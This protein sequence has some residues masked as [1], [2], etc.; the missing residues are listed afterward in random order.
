MAYYQTGPRDVFYNHAH[1]Q[2][3]EIATEG[4]ALALVPMAVLVCALAWRVTRKLRTDRG[5]GM[6]LRAGAAGAL[7][8]LAIACL[9]ESPFRTPAT[10]MLAAVAAGLGTHEE[11]S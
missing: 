1:N 4:G 5:S 2:Y 8:G 7:A 3:V 11:H 10:L 9:W 6:W